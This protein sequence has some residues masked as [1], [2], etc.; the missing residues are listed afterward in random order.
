VDNKKIVAG[1][2][3][4]A[5]VGILSYFGYKV[6]KELNAI[7]DDDIWKDFDNAF[8]FKHNRPNAD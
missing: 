3:G 2:A 4:V 8:N 1:V 5:V 7:V 6:F